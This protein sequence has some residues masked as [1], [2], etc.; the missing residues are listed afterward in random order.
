M[1][2]F[3]E[4]AVQA[5]T[6]QYNLWRKGITGRYIE[7]RRSPGADLPI[8]DIQPTPGRRVAVGFEGSHF[9]VTK[10]RWTSSVAA[11]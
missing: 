3:G 1:T 9:L 8:G 11:Q 5:T 10:V 7:R 6:D 4:Y 2:A